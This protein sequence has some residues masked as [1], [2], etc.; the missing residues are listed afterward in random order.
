[1]D[2]LEALTLHSWFFSFTHLDFHTR[3][4]DII[5]GE[6]KIHQHVGDVRGLGQTFVQQRLFKNVTQWI[7]I[8]KTKEKKIPS[9]NKFRV[10]DDFSNKGIKWTSCSTFSVSAGHVQDCFWTMERRDA[11]EENWNPEPSHC[12]ETLNINSI[13]DVVLT[14]R[15]QAERGNI[16]RFTRILH[17]KHFRSFWQI[18]NYYY[19]SCCYYGSCCYYRY[20]NCYIL[21]SVVIIV[22]IIILVVVMICIIIDVI[23]IN[24]VVVIIVV[25]SM[26]LLL[27][28]LL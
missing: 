8:L 7:Y 23:I 12:E 10:W 21:I 1:M 17:A 3:L 27:L 25:I 2:Y 4:S 5:V 18:H 9:E 28:L 13:V 11:G 22:V 20:Y 14:F 16:T 19:Y 15:I 24:A 6:N 26:L